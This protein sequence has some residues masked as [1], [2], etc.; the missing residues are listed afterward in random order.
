LCE[1]N[2]KDVEE[3]KREYI[4][5]IKFSYVKN[6]ID[7]VNLSLLEEKVKNP[8]DFN[9]NGTSMKNQK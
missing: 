2:R 9:S 5:D 1:E 4:K 7:V 8:I 6:M 3:I